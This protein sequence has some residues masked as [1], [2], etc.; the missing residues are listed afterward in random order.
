MDPAPWNGDMGTWMGGELPFPT[1][2]LLNGGALL[3]EW[4]SLFMVELSRNCYRCF[5]AVKYIATSETV[6][7]SKLCCGKPGV[8]HNPDKPLLASVNN[9]RIVS[10]NRC[11][12]N[13]NTN[14][15]HKW[16]KDLRGKPPQGEEGKTT[17]WTNRSTQASLWA[18]LVQSL[19]RTSRDY[20]TLLL[21]A[22]RQQQQ[23]PQEVRYNKDWDITVSVLFSN[24]RTA[25]KP[26]IQT[27]RNFID[28]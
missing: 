4:V 26:Q 20:N 18:T 16:H 8:T 2:L 12:G 10:T 5:L 25:L 22:H 15:M 1:T 3:D 11:N 27:A 19:S 28:K 7:Q 17:V 6:L 14:T 13:M 21:V 23:Q 9:L 24:Q